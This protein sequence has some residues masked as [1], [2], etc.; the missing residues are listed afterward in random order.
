V[1]GF[2]VARIELFSQARP[3]V[4]KF[5]VLVTDGKANRD[6]EDTDNEADLTKA[7]DVEV[8]AVGVTDDVSHFH[9]A[10]ITDSYFAI[11]RACA[12]SLSPSFL[13]LFL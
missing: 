8:F 7:S 1:Q 4:T 13:L 11:W 2:R 6:P 9:T 3:N 10:T 5:A 12:V